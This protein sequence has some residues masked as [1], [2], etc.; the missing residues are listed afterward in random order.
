VLDLQHNAH[1]YIETDLA[2]AKAGLVRV[3]LNPRLLAA[4]LAF[5]A[6]DARARGL[7]FGRGFAAQAE[8]LLAKVDGIDVVVGVERG[9]GRPDEDVLAA[10]VPNA[11]APLRPGP[12]TLASLNYS[13]GTTGR[14]KGLHAHGRQ[15]HGQPPRRPR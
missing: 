13:S 12:G 5:I 3:A 15:P 11:P 6:T 10:G 8:E 1:T 9:P 7:V 14:P 2:M 4:D